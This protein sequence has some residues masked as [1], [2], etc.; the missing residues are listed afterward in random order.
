MLFGTPDNKN[1]EMKKVL[2]LLAAIVILASSCMDKLTPSMTATPVTQEVSYRGGDVNVHL[3]TEFPWISSTDFDELVIT[4]SAG[5][6]NTDVK[7]T[8]PAS[9]SGFTRNFKVKFTA[10]SDSS[11]FVKNIVITQQY[12]PGK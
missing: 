5:V 10:K 2:I 3:E 12:N 4:P 9:E 7:I 8:V 11:T 6:G 1:R